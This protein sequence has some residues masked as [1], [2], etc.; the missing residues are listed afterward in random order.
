MNKKKKEWFVTI[1]DFLTHIKLSEARRAKYFTAIDFKN[2]KIPKKYIKE[3]VEFDKNGRAINAKTKELIVK[4][5]KTAGTPRYWKING[6]DLWSGNL[7]HSVRAKMN[8]Q[9]HNHFAKYII[10][11]IKIEQN[12]KLIPLTS[13]ERLQIHF[14]FKDKLEQSQDIDNMAIIYVKTFL[15]TLTQSSNKNQ[16]NIQKTNLIPDDNLRYIN[17]VSYR[18]EQSEQRELLVTIKKV[19]I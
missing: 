14:L 7:H 12:T 2:N 6:Q 11:Q 3:G 10:E 17:Q 9:L 8:E 18:F 5:P 16:T 15:D 1:S 19:K 13:D 4:N